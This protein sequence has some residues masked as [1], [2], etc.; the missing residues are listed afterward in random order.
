MGNGRTN[1][2]GYSPLLASNARRPLALALALSVFRGQFLG[3]SAH[4]VARSKFER[5]LGRRTSEHRVNE[6]EVRQSPLSVAPL[7]PGQIMPRNPGQKCPETYE[8]R[9]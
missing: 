6:N 1:E 2:N 7:I 4:L 9:S 8:H 5:R 3:R